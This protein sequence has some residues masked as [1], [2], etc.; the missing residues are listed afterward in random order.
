MEIFNEIS[1]LKAFLH[2]KRSIG[3]SIGLV[4]TMGVLH[5]GHL[6]LL[7][8]CQKENDLTICSI[9]VNPA[10]F[11]NPDDLANYPRTLERD[12]ELLKKVQCHALFCP[13][14]DQMYPQPP[15]IRF[16]IEPLDSVM[17]GRY[18]PGHFS[19][20]ALV[21][22]KFFNLI[23]PDNAYFGQKDWQQFVII[24]QL[25]DELKFGLK[26]HAMPIVREKDGLAKSSR[27]LRLTAAQRLVA[28][29]F[30]QALTEAKKHISAGES[31]EKV[32]VMITTMVNEKE[33]VR[34][35]YFEVAESQNLTPVSNVEKANSPILCIAG[36]LGEV[37]LIDNMFLNLP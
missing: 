29:V 17:E 21:V 28:P 22:A 37:R 23:M 2:S 35:E 32:K 31:I 34:L 8:K 7:E 14:N 15:M 24:R 3:K 19:G 26:L 25:V 1:P 6:S 12:I 9:Y 20:V 10:Q 18:R 4:P 11:N 13:S 36:Y 27:N 5:E 16:N 30:F 33:G